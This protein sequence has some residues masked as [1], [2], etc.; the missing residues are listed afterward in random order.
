MVKSGNEPHSCYQDFG[1]TPLGA[2]RLAPS[3]EHLTAPQS[4]PRPP[5]TG[6]GSAVGGKMLL[7][8]M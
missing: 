4:P 1:N 2:V 7:R 8:R 5:R 6:R 3:T